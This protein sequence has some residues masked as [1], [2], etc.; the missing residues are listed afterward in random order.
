MVFGN[1]NKLNDTL[2]AKYLC[3]GKEGFLIGCDRKYAMLSNKKNVI[4]TLSAGIIFLYTV[5]KKKKE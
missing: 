2:K 5:F 1:I 4:M 3:H